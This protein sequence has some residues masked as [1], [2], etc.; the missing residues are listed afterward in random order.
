MT[1]RRHR[2]RVIGIVPLQ[3]DV[4]GH[5]VLHAVLTQ[6]RVAVGHGVRCSSSAA[7]TGQHGVWC[8]AAIDSDRMALS[9]QCVAQSSMSNGR[10]KVETFCPQGT[11][12]LSPTTPY[13]AHLQQGECDVPQYCSAGS[14]VADCA[15]SCRCTDTA[16][17]RT[18]PRG[19]SSLLLARAAA[20]QDSM[21]LPPLDLRAA[22]F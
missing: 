14:D 13:T 3:R 21:L 18:P 4:A 15:D 5:L 1:G 16:S 11:R 8:D 19:D 12:R 6:A 7:R 20:A 2:W 9:R 10:R 17:L 22:A